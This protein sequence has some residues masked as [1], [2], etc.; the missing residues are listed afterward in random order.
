MVQYA[1]QQVTVTVNQY[2]ALGIVT[3]G[4]IE[5]KPAVTSRILQNMQATAVNFNVPVNS[6]YFLVEPQEADRMKTIHMIIDN[7]GYHTSD[8]DIQ[9]GD[10]F[11]KVMIFYDTIINLAPQ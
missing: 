1:Q 4:T 6:Y 10:A 5:G 11:P 8:Y 3:Q 2:N 9:T 7:D